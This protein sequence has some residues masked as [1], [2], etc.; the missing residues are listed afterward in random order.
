VLTLLPETLTALPYAFCYLSLSSS[1]SPRSLVSKK[2]LLSIIIDHP[3][4]HPLTLTLTHLTSPHPLAFFCVAVDLQTVF[5]FCTAFRVA[6]LFGFFTL[7]HIVNNHPSSI[8]HVRS[9]PTVSIIII[10]KKNKTIK[11]IFRNHHH[12]LFC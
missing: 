1:L 3:L 10:N 7:F 8:S 12:P 11:F 4:L 5:L 9:L 6:C 2:L